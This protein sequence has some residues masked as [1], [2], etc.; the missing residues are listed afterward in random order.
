MNINH[1]E[2]WKKSFGLLPIHLFAN[3]NDSNDF[4]LLN[5]GSGDFCF[6]TSLQDINPNDYN[7]RAWSSNTKNFVVLDNEVIHLYNWK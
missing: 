2:T 4:I 7:S 5:G 6:S 3:G 1:I